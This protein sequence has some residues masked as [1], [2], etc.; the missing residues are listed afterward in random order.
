MLQV[1]LL[2]GPSTVDQG[3]SNFLGDVPLH[4][5]NTFSVPPIIILC[6]VTQRCQQHFHRFCTAAVR[7]MIVTLSVKQDDILTAGTHR[8][9]V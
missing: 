2:F 3:F 9:C 6:A 1:L 7:K 8:L 4:E 5:F